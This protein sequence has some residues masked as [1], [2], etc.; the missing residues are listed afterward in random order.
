MEQ[1]GVLLVYH[2]QTDLN[3]PSIFRAKPEDLPLYFHQPT[4]GN[5]WD[6]TVGNRNKLL[7]NRDLIRSH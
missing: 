5:F 7:I 1:L 4:N 3:P 2:R 6:I